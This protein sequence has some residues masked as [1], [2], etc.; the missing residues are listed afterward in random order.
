MFS[1]FRFAALFVAIPAFAL[2]PVLDFTGGRDAQGWVAAHDVAAMEPSPDGLKLKAS[3]GDPFLH[4]PRGDFTAK[5]PLLFTAT[6]RSEAAGWAQVFAS[7]DADR[8]SQSAQVRLQAGWNEISLVLP[9]MGKD[10]RLRFD[11]V[12][13]CTIARMGVVESGTTGI[14]AVEVRE[15]FITLKFAGID[16]GAEVVEIRAGQPISAGAVVTPQLELQGS[17]TMSFPRFHGKSDR[18]SNGFVAMVKHPVLGK[19]PVGGVRFADSLP[20]AK[21]ARPF[22]KT[23]SKKGLQVQMVDDAIALGVRHAGLNLS[24]G[25]LIDLSKK[26]GNPTWQL[27]GE[28]YSFRKSYLDSLNVKKLT[29]SGMAVYLIILAI[30]SNQPDMDAAI[31][32]PSRDAQLPNKIA[33]FDTTTPRGERL[34]R[35][36]MEFLADWF[37][38][39]NDENGR[40][41]GYVIGNEVN[42][43]W[44]WHNLGRMPRN[45]MVADYERQMRLANTAVRKS[46]ATARVYMSLTHFWTIDPDKDHWRSMPGKYLI[47]EFA[48]QAR[49]GGD[50]DWHLAHHPYP[51]NLG[52]P[53]TWEDKTAPQTQEAGRIT[54]KNLEQLDQ[55][56]ARP[57]NLYRGKQ[58]SIILSEQ[59]FHAKE[60]P[61][62]ERDQAAGYCYAWAKIARIPS[63]EAFILHRHVDH[64]YEGGL[65]LGLWTRKPESIATP[66][67]QRPMYQCFKAAGTPEEEAAFR[68]ALPVIGIENW[69]AVLVK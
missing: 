27:D 58:R 23:D 59:G 24:L 12:G 68:F 56:F 46:S 5:G 50:Y 2:P 25:A 65:N 51:E 31:L 9:P 49:A 37:S 44:Q 67:K 69:D 30:Q 21:D 28:T 64:Q 20:P 26:P 42:V 45:A 10:W 19:V 55:F 39:P 14:V 17:K 48:R 38:R 47:E 18:A 22:P 1:L 36:T 53:R 63:I 52:N 3:G 61:N 4:S 15:K 62:G 16:A 32:H 66:D 57:E 60:K 7:K 33:A 40:V 41:A 13:D 34:W 29:E 6:I 11:P 54:F 35:A 43:H 8:E